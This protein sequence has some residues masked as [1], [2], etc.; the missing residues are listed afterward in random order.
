MLSAGGRTHD[1]PWATVTSLIAAGC[2]GGIAPVEAARPAQAMLVRGLRGLE[3]DLRERRRPAGS[4]G[5][6]TVEA[7]FAEL[8]PLGLAA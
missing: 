3:R 6:G 8:R 4:E 7:A 5:A 2:I 1:G